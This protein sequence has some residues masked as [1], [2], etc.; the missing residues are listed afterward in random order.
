LTQAV[1]L[2]TIVDRDALADLLAN[3]PGLVHARREDSGAHFFVPIATADQEQSPHECDKQIAAVFGDED[4]GELPATADEAAMWQPGA[5]YRSVFVRPATKRA[6]ARAVE[7]APG[8]VFLE[9]TSAV[10]NEYEGW[11]TDAPEDTYV[12][13]G[14]GPDSRRWFA[15]I[16]WSKRAGRWMVS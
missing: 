2:R 9:E 4:R 5:V 11:L 14:P 6:L 15:T 1:F 16:R 8:D 13:V 10:G 12:V 3:G 7:V